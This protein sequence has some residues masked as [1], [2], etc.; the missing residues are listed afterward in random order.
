[1]RRAG[2]EAARG[3]GAT[4]WQSPRG[5]KCIVWTTERRRGP[6]LC[7]SEGCRGLLSSPG[8]IRSINFGARIPF[9][10]KLRCGT[11]LRTPH[12]GFLLGWVESNRRRHHG[13]GSNKAQWIGGIK[14]AGGKKK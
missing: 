14:T 10:F 7:G 12:Y 11:R 4:E 8:V 5:E 2:F 6:I 9:A 1:M 3:I 13:K